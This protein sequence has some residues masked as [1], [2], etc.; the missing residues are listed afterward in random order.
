[1]GIIK[2]SRRAGLNP[3]IFI[4]KINQE[5][6]QIHRDY[7]VSPEKR[8][9]DRKYNERIASAESIMNQLVGYEK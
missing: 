3:D 4:P 6:M 1:M 2:T 7:L 5:L 8:E 9:S